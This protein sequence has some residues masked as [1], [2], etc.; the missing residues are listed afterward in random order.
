MSM[1]ANIYSALDSFLLC[2][3]A[4]AWALHKR[5]AHEMKRSG[6]QVDVKVQA[7][8]RRGVRMDKNSEQA[9][10]ANGEPGRQ[11]WLRSEKPR[12]AQNARGKA[13]KEQVRRP[14][15]GRRIYNNIQELRVHGRAP[16]KKLTCA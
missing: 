15:W 5:A 10:G 16:A 8:R 11:A 1:P 14:S 7:R 6:F 9:G 2:A 4:T 12:R 3:F 13:T